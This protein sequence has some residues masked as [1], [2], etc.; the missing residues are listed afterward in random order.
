M[1]AENACLNLVNEFRS[2]PT[3]RSGSLITTVFGDAIAPRG[4]T[5]WLGSLIKVLADF[6]VSERLVRTSVFRLVKDG[7][8]QSDQIGRR[9]Y[10][11]LTDQ[12]RERFEQA[13]H[14]IYGTPASDWNG[15]W[16]LLLL[17]TLDTETRE[18]VRKECGWLGFGPMSANVLAHPLPDM[19]ELDVT[20]RRL[21][22]ADKLIVMR[23]TTIKSEAAMRELTRSC[24]SLDDIDARYRTFVQ[25]FRPL[26][27]ALSG[28][29][30]LSQLSEKSAFVVRTL[31]IQEY[32]KVLLRD[33]WL[34]AEL[35]PGNW[36][37]AAAY[38]LCRNLYRRVYAGADAYLDDTI[39]TADGPLPPPGPSFLQRFGGLVPSTDTE[40]AVHE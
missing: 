5:V 1:S 29:S 25:G 22:V 28:H 7:W 6:G 34:P 4:G 32:R 11:S 38:Q 18:R 12:G 37:G 19:A 13:T 8:L 39:E 16:C 15:E 3:L 33:P 26:I 24:W 31:L 23:G 20:I 27:K 40:Y 17:S 2:R 10:Y 30:K 35:L 36:H 9:S 21:G 14:R